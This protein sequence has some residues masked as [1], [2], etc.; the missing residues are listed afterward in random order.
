[1]ASTLVPVLV[2][3]LAVLASVLYGP[4]QHSLTVFGVFRSLNSTPVAQG[5]FV[6]IPDTV[7][8]EDLHYYEPAHLFFTACEDSAATRGIWFPPLGIFTAPEKIAGGSLHVVDP[9]VSF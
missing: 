8:C 2:V 1:M 9:E 7:H 5:D 4:V 3:G 6:S